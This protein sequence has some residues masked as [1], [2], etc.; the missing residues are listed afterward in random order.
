MPSP[1]RNI[2]RGLDVGLQST[3]PANFL[4][5]WQACG[6]ASCPNLCLN[7][8]RQMQALRKRVLQSSCSSFDGAAS[9]PQLSQPMVPAT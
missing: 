7:T 9:R 5:A 4:Q 8:F 6:F 3:L 1:A 2:A